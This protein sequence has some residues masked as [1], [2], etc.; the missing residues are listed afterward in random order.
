MILIRVKNE[1]INI[2]RKHRVCGV[3]ALRVCRRCLTGKDLLF[4]CCD[5]E[6]P[7][8]Y[9]WSVNMIV[10]A[11]GVFVVSLLLLISLCVF[12]FVHTPGCVPHCRLPHLPFISHHQLRRVTRVRSLFRRVAEFST[13]LL[14]SQ[15]R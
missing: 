9:I 10:S 14:H 3:V 15:T 8:L 11:C 1:H 13:R 12:M 6:R 5:R 7:A 4:V 2:K